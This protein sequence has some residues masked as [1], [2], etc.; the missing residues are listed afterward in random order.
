VLLMWR[1]QIA[2]YLGVAPARLAAKFPP[3]RTSAAQSG[4]GP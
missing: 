2:Y 3:V 4:A 1:L